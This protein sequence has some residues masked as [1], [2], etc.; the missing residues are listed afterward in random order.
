V[1]LEARIALVR[2]AWPM[3]PVDRRLLMATIMINDGTTIFYKYWG[4]Q[5]AQPIVFHHGWPLSSDDWDKLGIAD[6]VVCSA[7]E[8]RIRE[9]VISPTDV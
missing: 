5:G 9:H 2:D 7:Q 8:V 1:E 3:S 4:P 6:A